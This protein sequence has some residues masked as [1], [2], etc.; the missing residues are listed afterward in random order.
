MPATDK[1][2]RKSGS[3]DNNADRMDVDSP[4]LR[5]FDEGHSTGAPA[6]VQQV[7]VNHIEADLAECFST[8]FCPAGQ[9]S[10]QD[11]EQLCRS[12]IIA[13]AGPHFGLR[14]LLSPHRAVAYPALQE[15]HTQSH[16]KRP[17]CVTPKARV[18]F[19]L[20]ELE[21]EGDKGKQTDQSL[22]LLRSK[23]MLCTR[24]LSSL[25][26]G[27][28]R[29]EPGQL[30]RAGLVNSADE[31]HHLYPLLLSVVKAIGL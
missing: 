14:E 6:G 4:S 30:G 1:W 2:A 21:D 9:H 19:I 13:P 7:L 8:R 20:L 12:S 31:G 22:P 29:C 11:A 27:P 23:V 28:T 15:N 17:V 5:V 24:V 10:C 16:S 26:L 3:R 18:L 25:C